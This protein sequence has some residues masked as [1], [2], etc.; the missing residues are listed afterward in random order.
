MYNVTTT[1]LNYEV[2]Q[3]TNPKRR[4]HAIAEVDNENLA[5]L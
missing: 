3:S 5:A 1:R 4:A 2:I